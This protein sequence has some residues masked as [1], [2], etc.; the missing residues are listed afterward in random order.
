MEQVIEGKTPEI[1]IEWG[2][3][4]AVSRSGPPNCGPWAPTAFDRPF[5]T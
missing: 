1:T 5:S 2:N 3:G 4:D